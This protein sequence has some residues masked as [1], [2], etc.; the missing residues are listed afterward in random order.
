MA[1]KKKSIDSVQCFGRKKTATAVAYCKR[2]SGLLKVNG[3]PIELMEPEGMRFKV[4]EPVKLLGEERFGG[5]DIRVRV[6]GGGHTARVYAIRQAVAKSMV[7]FYQKC[8]LLSSP[9][10]VAPSRLCVRAAPCGTC[11]QRTPGSLSPRDHLFC[12]W[13]C[14]GWCWWPWRWWWRWWWWWWWLQG[15]KTILYSHTE[16]QMLSQNRAF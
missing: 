5:V 3:Q 12:G 13:H 1:D 14:V 11:N 9:P 2:G 10:T 15:C 6:R 16:S 4:L 8:K 7:A